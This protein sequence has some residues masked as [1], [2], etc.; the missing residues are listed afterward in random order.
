MD[1]LPRQDKVLTPRTKNRIFFVDEDYENGISND[2]NKI[3]YHSKSI[4]KLKLN[5]SAQNPIT[6]LN[7]KF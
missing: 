3:F 6:Y 7:P 4:S 2:K 5:Q 1:K